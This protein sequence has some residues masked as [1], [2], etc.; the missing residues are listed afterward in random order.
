MPRTA[1]ASA[2][3][4]VLGAASGSASEP[5]SYTVTVNTNVG[6]RVGYVYVSG[7]VHTIVQKGRTGA[8]SAEDL[9]VESE[10]GSESVAL[11]FDGRFA[12]DA[13]PNV[14]WITVQPTHGV[15]A[16]AI[17]CTI[18]PYNEVGTRTGSVTF[19]MTFIR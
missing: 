6:E 18:A 10:G 2:P 19:G 11:D 1:A 4:I 5:L 8:V 12:W 7:R 16:G 15:G 13:R 17:D 3:W 9:V 14:D